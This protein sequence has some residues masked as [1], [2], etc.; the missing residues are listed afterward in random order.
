[1]PD[2]N[3]VRRS[4]VML[5][6][7]TRGLTIDGPGWILA[8]TTQKSARITPGTRVY[9]DIRDDDA[10][11]E[12]GKDVF[13][14]KR[15]AFT[16]FRLDDN[17]GRFSTAGEVVEY[18]NNVESAPA[19]F[20]RTVAQQ[21]GSFTAEMG[22]ITVVDNAAAPLDVTLPTVTSED[23]GRDIILYC[24]KSPAESP[25]NIYAAD[26]TQT[27]NAVAAAG[28]QLARAVYN[29][30]LKQ[31]AII[32]ITVI[33][34]NSFIAAEADASFAALVFAAF[35]E[36]TT[37]SSGQNNGAI[38]M[39]HEAGLLEST[40]DWWFAI[41]FEQ[42]PG[43]GEVENMSIVS[44]GNFA[45]GWWA[46]QGRTQGM[47]TLTATSQN[48]LNGVETTTHNPLEQWLVMSYDSTTGDLNAWNNGAHVVIDQPISPSGT[49]GTGIVTS[50][51]PLFGEMGAIKPIPG[52][53][54]SAIMFGVGDQLT[55]QDVAEFTPTRYLLSSLPADVQSKANKAWSFDENG[56]VAALGGA[57]TFGS[58]ITMKETV[59][60]G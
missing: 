16:E 48:T 24:K 13:I 60:G 31:Y 59:L 21:S 9:V 56:A 32:R 38:N 33:G 50:G 4:H 51:S 53:L 15:I 43:V 27:I 8:T 26:A 3:I 37:P 22:Q 30:S 49:M 6:Y 55:A 19:T 41:K 46:G 17:S 58:L 42:S 54:V 10:S 28:E 2:I 45:I 18:I 11:A 57:V 39:P 35:G 7:S 12:N 14:A 52:M 29:A 23:I 20:S 40:D 25:V 47:T 44:H 36:N 5:T 34:E 1:M